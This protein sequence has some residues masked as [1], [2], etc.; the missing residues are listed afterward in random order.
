MPYQI[1]QLGEIL[2][3]IWMKMVA[4]LGAEFLFKF[5]PHQGLVRAV[6]VLNALCWCFTMYKV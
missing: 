1:M 6:I 5:L 4:N 2:I 3:H